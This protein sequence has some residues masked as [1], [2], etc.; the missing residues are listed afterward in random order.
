[1]TPWATRPETAADAEAVRAVNL[2]A[3]SF[4]PS[5]TPDRFTDTPYQLAIRL[6]DVNSHTS[7]HLRFSGIFNGIMTDSAIQLQTKFTSPIR[8][9]LVLGKSVYTVTLT[10]YAPPGPPSEGSEGK[11]SAYVE[12]H[13]AHAPEPSSLML[14]G[15]G[16]VGTTLSWLRRRRTMLGS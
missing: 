12:V 2:A 3:F 5:S 14:A 9:S 8:Q 13:T 11:I 4:S 1:M 7:G 16:L 15:T 6:T 10:S